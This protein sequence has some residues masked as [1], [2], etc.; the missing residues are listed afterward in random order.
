M[1]CGALVLLAAVLDVARAGGL[2]F[3][4][5]CGSKQRSD[6][7]GNAELSLKHG[8]LPG[9]LMMCGVGQ[10]KQKLISS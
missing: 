4:A 8:H 5:G 9:S 1:A 7:D 3:G 10:A 6:N 2:E